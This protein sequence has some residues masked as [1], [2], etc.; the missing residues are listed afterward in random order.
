MK[1]FIRIVSLSMFL[2]LS[3]CVFGF[4]RSVDA[5]IIAPP[6]AAQG[7][8]CTFGTYKSGSVGLS[9]RGIDK[10]GPHG[11]EINA[12]Y[13]VFYVVINE[14]GPPV[15]GFAGFLYSSF[16]GSFDFAP[17]LNDPL[18]AKYTASVLRVDPPSSLNQIPL[19]AWITAL[20]KVDNL[21]PQL[22]LLRSA[23]PGSVSTAISPCFSAPVD[24]NPD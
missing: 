7:S 16:D 17:M 8:R 1:R 20:A 22:Q 2:S 23:A 24:A 21:E 13:R 9:L 3:T 4:I 15:S 10:P 11:N 5:S 12:I 6:A 19:V 14:K 18:S